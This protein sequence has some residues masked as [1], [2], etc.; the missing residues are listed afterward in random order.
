MLC[1]FKNKNH[2]LLE[3][4]EQKLT[5]KELNQSKNKQTF[6]ITYCL[7]HQIVHWTHLLSLKGGN[8][9]YYSM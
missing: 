5:I 1:Y 9:F 8:I 2:S 6:L 3:K 4:K 7:M